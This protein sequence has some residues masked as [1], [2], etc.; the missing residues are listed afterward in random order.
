MMVKRLDGTGCFSRKLAQTWER[1]GDRVLI[2][3]QDVCMGRDLAFT[4]I[5]TNCCQANR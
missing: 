4:Q 5:L 2:I 1:S 3:L